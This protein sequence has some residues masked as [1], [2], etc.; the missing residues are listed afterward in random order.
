MTFNADRLDP[1]HLYLE[2]TPEVQSHAW[3]DSRSFATAASQWNAYLNQLCLETVLPWLREDYEPRTTPAPNETA[4]PSFWELVNGTAVKL[5]STRL[6]L[7]PTEAID[8]D[9]LRVPQEWVDIP[10]WVGDYYV[11][12][13]VNPDDRWVRIGGFA[14]HQQLKDSSY[15]WSDRT[16]SLDDADLTSDFSALWVAHQFA[17]NTSTRAAVAPLPSLPLSQAEN[18]IQRL[19][20]PSLLAPRLELPF[21]TW[22]AL[23][24]HGGWRQRLADQRRGIPE[25][26]SVIDWLQTGISNLG[27]QIGWTPIEFQP[28]FAGARGSATSSPTLGIAKEVNIIGQPYELRIL[29]LDRTEDRT[30]HNHWRFELNSLTLG[31]TIPPGV[32]LRL[33]TEDLQPFEGNEDTATTPVEQ[34]YVEVELETGEGL[35]W[36]IEPTPEN[37]DREILRF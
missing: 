26:R 10:D 4:L 8:L 33:L 32:T 3:N 18:L 24:S 16:Y 27:Q 29:T 23:V 15:Q 5:G 31:G 6:V 7:I 25:R 21:Q 19:S 22:G 20:N 34:L 28:A 17:P 12:V 37:Y 1:T 2:I 13:Q 36:E 14:T 11:L 30:E 9:E 35:V